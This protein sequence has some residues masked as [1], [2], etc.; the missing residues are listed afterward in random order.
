M[1]EKKKKVLPNTNLTI[2]ACCHWTQAYYD[3]SLEIIKPLFFGH[4]ICY[5]LIP[6]QISNAFNQTFHQTPAHILKSIKNN[7]NANPTT[8][9][10]LVQGP[11]KCMFFFLAFTRITCIFTKIGKQAHLGWGHTGITSNRILKVQLHFT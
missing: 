11:E 1:R 3:C 6:Y 9:L 4:Y 10:Y 2:L 8:E 7:Q 5:S